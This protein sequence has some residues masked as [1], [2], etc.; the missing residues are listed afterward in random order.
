MKQKLKLAVIQT[1]SV[2]QLRDTVNKMVSFVGKAKESGCRAAVF[3]EGALR[4][5]TDNSKEEIDAAIKLIRNSAAYNDIYIIFGLL[6]RNSEN[7]SLHNQALVVGPDGEIIQTYNKIWENTTLSAPGIFEIDG[8]PCGMTIC[9]D[10]WLRIVEELPA[11]KGAK[12]LIELS[13]NYTDEWIDDLGWFWY[14]PRAVRNNAFVVLA[15]SPYDRPVEEYTGYGSG[16]GHSVIIA[17]DGSPLAI[18]GGEN[19]RILAAELDLG[20]AALKEAGLR[21]NHSV[22]KDFWETGIRI[23]DGE[24]VGL[25]SHKPLAVPEA[26]IKIAAA[27]MACSCD[28]SENIAVIQRLI[29]EAGANNAD[30][31]VFPELAVT[32][33]H[34]D[35]IRLA[36]EE[37][38]ASALCDISNA[39]RKAHVHVAFG[40]PLL[41][42]GK[43]WNC[44]YVI[45]PGGELLTCHAELNPRDGCLFEQGLSTKSLWFEIK[46]VPSVITLGREALWSEIAELAAVR[47]ARIHLHLSNDCDT[48]DSG[49]LFRRQLFLQLASFRTFTATVNAALPDDLKRPGSPAGGRSAIWEDFNRGSKHNTPG[50]TGFAPYSAVRLK[51]AGN[52]EQMLYAEQTIKGVNPQFETIAS[53]NPQMESWYRMGSQV[54]YRNMQE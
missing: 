39:A 38:L 47:G 10:R 12:I 4:S 7:E 42:K 30:I 33:T 35:D 49:M 31:V 20:R 14:I 40:M 9:A 3:P 21:Y 32:G 37:L 45:G 2:C 54:I 43:C 34:A 18:A 46:G 8:I 26:N 6:Y 22:L 23:M 44:A 25:P 5:S 19:G 48:S 29:T 11:F 52:T 53:I 50:Y 36:G 28:I 17:P 13:N 16:H 24:K 27:Q 41:Q 51:E 1:A 15:N